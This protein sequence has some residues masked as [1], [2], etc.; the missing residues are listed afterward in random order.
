VDDPIESRPAVFVDLD[1]A[2]IE[3][4]DTPDPV[5]PLRFLPGAPEGLGALYRAGFAV[6][7]V[8]NQSGLALGQF[9]RSQFMGREA[10]LQW[11]LRDE[12]QVVLADILVCPH[13]PGRYGAPACLCRMPAPGLLIRAARTHRFDLAASWMVGA[14]L[15]DIEAGR[16]A[17]CRTVLLTGVPAGSEAVVPLRLSPLRRPH[18]RCADWS[19]VAQTLLATPHSPAATPPAAALI[20]R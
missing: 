3:R 17:G 20:A 8:T 4:A 14:S 6:V 1:G 15:D 10:A 18:R 12:A 16:R 13:R 5:A 11:R 9:T 19:E 2:L 7:V